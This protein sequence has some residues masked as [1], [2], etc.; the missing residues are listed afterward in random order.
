MFFE[1]SSLSAVKLILGL[2]WN[3]EIL[4][5]CIVHVT[6]IGHYPKYVC[7]VIGPHFVFHIAHKNLKSEGSKRLGTRLHHYLCSK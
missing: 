5:F 7:D 4:M 2:P 3:L 1:A 6:V